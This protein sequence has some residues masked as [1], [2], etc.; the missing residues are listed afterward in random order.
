MKEGS[1]QYDY[2]VSPKLLYEYTGFY[3]DEDIMNEQIWPLATLEAVIKN[4][5]SIN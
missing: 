3:F 1:S 5:Y 4:N 2:Y